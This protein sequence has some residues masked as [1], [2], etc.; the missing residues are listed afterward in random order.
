MLTP[1]M[2]RNTMSTPTDGASAH[3]IEEPT[4]TAIPQITIRRRPTMSPSRPAAIVHE[5]NISTATLR[6][7]ASSAVPA[8][9]S[10]PKVGRATTK[11]NVSM[12]S[13]SIAR[14]M[15]TTTHHRRLSSVIPMPTARGYSAGKRHRAGVPWKRVS[16]RG[17]A[18]Q[19]CPIPQNPLHCPGQPIAVAARIV[20]H[21][22][23]YAV[24][25]AGSVRAERPCAGQRCRVLSLMV[26]LYGA[27][28]A[29]LGN[30]KDPIS[31]GVGESQNGVGAGTCQR[32]SLPPL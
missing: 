25:R 20:R 23:T 5:P 16:L 21:R 8:L 29:K 30:A 32:E 1:S 28:S 13:G 15:A 26:A 7:Q 27:R 17:H 14:V 3:P 24:A 4:I 22:A 6:I 31:S 11:P 9:N 19:P 2:P 12:L 18:L 10:D